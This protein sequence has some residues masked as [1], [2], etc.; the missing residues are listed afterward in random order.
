MKKFTGAL[1]ALVTPFRDGAVDFE[2]LDSLVSE[3]I[4]AGVSGLVPCG[5][6]GE[7]AALSVDEHVAVVRRVITAAKGRVPVIAGVGSPSTARSV[8]LTTLCEKAGVDGLLAVTPY[9]VKPNALGL[10]KHF[11]TVARS[12]SL[13]VILYNVPGRTGVDLPLEVTL[14]L[15]EEPNIVGLKDATGNL[16]RMHEMIARLP[17]HFSVLSGEDGIILPTLAVGGAGV[18]SVITHVVGEAVSKMCA[19]YEKG[20]LA[21]ARQHAVRTLPFARLLFMDSN[22]IPVKT[23]LAAMGLIREEWRL[24]MGPMASDKRQTLLTEL[25]ALGLEIRHGL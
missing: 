17:S 6:T 19:A 25:K 5:T 16:Q 15:S 8:E 2:A 21:D 13:P 20:H 9:Y 7:A 23:A 11:L 10:Q 1:T 3:Q 18:I 14:A 4:R 22:P 12:T 24:P